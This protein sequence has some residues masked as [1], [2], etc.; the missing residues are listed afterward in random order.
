MYFPGF[1]LLQLL[2]E[3]SSP[4]SSLVDFKVIEDLLELDVVWL[5]WGQELARAMQCV[6]RSNVTAE[7]LADPKVALWAMRMSMVGQ[8]M[9]G[10]MG[11][12]L[13]MHDGWISTQNN[14]MMLTTEMKSVTVT[15]F[16]MMKKSF[17]RRTAVLM[18]SAY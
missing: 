13:A 5:E 16:F 15:L 10:P 1:F 12:I 2:D 11:T 8:I 18:H 6:A 4:C 17:D 3:S 9:T 7:R 14:S